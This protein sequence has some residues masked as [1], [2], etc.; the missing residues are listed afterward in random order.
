MLGVCG[1]AGP[2]GRWARPVNP[3]SPSSLTTPGPATHGRV[4][5]AG[6]RRWLVV[7][8]HFPLPPHHSS[9]SVAVALLL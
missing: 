6:S 2:A 7:E 5:T 4:T 3:V 8:G 9:P 1:A